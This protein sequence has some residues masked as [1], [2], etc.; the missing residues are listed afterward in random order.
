MKSGKILEQEETIRSA[1][2]EAIVYCTLYI[3]CKCKNGFKT[4]AC[5]CKNAGLTCTDA[6]ICNKMQDCE[7]ENDYYCHDSSDNEE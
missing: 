7:N 5:R 4:N 2:P 6:C 1:V 3:L